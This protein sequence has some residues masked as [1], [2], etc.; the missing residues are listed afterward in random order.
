MENYEINK[1]T[2]AII[3]I[4]EEISKV[5]EEEREFII[6]ASVM[7]IIDDSCKFFW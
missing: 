5:I 2:L 4:E 3:P 6:N 1:E 7:K